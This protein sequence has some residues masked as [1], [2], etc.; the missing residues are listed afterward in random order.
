MESGGAT[1]GGNAVWL[2]LQRDCQGWSQEG[3]RRRQQVRGPEVAVPVQGVMESQT[4]RQLARVSGSECPSETAVGHSCEGSEMFSNRL[5]TLKT[6]LL[7]PKRFLDE[8]LQGQEVHG[9]LSLKGHV[10]VVYRGRRGQVTD[11]GHHR[12]SVKCLH[13]NTSKPTL[14]KPGACPWEDWLFVRQQ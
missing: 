9:C 11:Q 14:R 7:S 8:P 12:R 2:P 6:D 13:I 1:E 10:A 5:L 3:F 4:V